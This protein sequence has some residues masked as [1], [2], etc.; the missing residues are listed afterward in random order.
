MALLRAVKSK[1][2][3]ETIHL[4]LEASKSRHHC[5]GRTYGSAALCHAVR[6][7]DF[8]MVGLLCGYVDIDGI[9]SLTGE[10]F[11]PLGQAILMSN[12]EM[13]ELLLGQG[14]NVNACISHQGLDIPEH[15]K[16]FL[17]RVTPLL[18]AID[19]QSFPIVEL[20]VERGAE[21][22]YTRSLGILRT[23]LARAAENGNLVI[24]QYFLG[25]GASIDTIPLCSGGTALQ[26]AA[27]NGHVG[28]AK[29][30]L[31]HNADANYPPCGGDGRTAFEGAAEGG[32]I[33]MMSL[34]MERGVDLNFQFGDPSESQ[35]MRSRRFAEQKGLMASRREVERLYTQL[36]KQKQARLKEPQMHTSSPS[37]SSEMSLYFD[38]NQFSSLGNGQDIFHEW[39]AL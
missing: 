16:S 23:P 20:L 28:I 10:G 14:A 9:E 11:N 19:V 33:D 21:I 26:L 38:F 39:E 36:Q 31:S 18:A 15:H 27:I 30:L 37:S 25:Q 4:L 29:L 17:P 6:E 22:D 13:I 8:D 3:V 2:K 32:H 5:V 24:V 12:L 34:L 7:L 35:Y 1:A